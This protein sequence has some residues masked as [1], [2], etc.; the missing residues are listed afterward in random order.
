VELKPPEGAIV[1]MDVADPPAATVA[2]DNAGA[3]SENVGVP[4]T[5]RLTVVVWVRL[6]AVPLIVTV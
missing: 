4:A 1:I 6:P 2:G 3:V 5:V